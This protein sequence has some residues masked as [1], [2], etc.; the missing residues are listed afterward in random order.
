LPSKSLQ[1]CALKEHNPVLTD[2]VWG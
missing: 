1:A 2:N